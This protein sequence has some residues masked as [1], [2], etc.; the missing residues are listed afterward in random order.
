ME[1]E[2]YNCRAALQYKTSNQMQQ[3][4]LV[5]NNHEMH[6]NFTMEDQPSTSK[7]KKILDRNPK[8]KQNFFKPY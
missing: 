6:I 1:K 7:K 2:E 8:F 3:T 5:S 4:N